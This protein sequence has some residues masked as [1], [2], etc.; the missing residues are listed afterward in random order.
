MRSTDQIVGTRSLSQDMVSFERACAANEG[1][2]ECVKLAL[3]LL[4]H[5]A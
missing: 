4:R 3:Q 1:V 5:D 2:I